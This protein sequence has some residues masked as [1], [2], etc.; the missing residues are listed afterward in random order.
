MEV[1]SRWLADEVQDLRLEHRVV[2]LDLDAR[3]VT[4][5]HRGRPKRFRYRH[6]CV[7][8]LPLPAV[9]KICRPVPTGLLQDLR[10]L[11]WNRVWS[12]AFAIEG[13]RPGVRPEIAE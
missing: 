13:A 7:T 1:L 12:A 4:A 2:D 11:K 8:T 6:A 3:C 10:H 5:L 9:A